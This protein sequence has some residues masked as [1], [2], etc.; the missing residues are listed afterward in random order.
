LGIAV[1][2]LEG[3]LL[4]ANPA[5]CSML[6]YREQ[7]LCAINCSEFDSKDECLLF[8]KLRA[9]LIDHYS[10]EKCYVRKDGVPIWAHLNVS[11][12]NRDESTPFVVAFVEDISK[13]KLIEEALRSSEQRYRVLFERNV[14]GVAIV[15][16]DGKILE[17]NDAWALIVGYASAD[18]IRGRRT[19]DFY[20]N[21]S[22]PEP[23][24]TELSQGPA[25]LV[26]EL[27]L[28]QKDGTPVWVL[29]SMT[30][31]SGGDRPPVIQVISVDITRRKLAE[32]ALSGAAR[33]LIEAQE[34][35]GA[36]VGRELHD[37]IGQRLGLLAVELQQMEQAPPDAA[38][39][40]SSRMQDLWKQASDLS[41]DVQA[42]SHGLRSAK[43][44]YLGVVS[45]MRSHCKEF[46][47]RLRIEVEFR[48]HDLPS[49]LPS[50]EISLSLFRVLQEALHNAAKHSGVRH[51]EV[52]LWGTPSEVHLKVSDS[53]AGFDP[54]VALRGRGIGLTTMKERLKL[55]N[56][57]LSVESRPGLGTMIHARAPLGSQS[58]SISVAG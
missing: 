10:L 52:E 1:E 23:I 51:L 30:L 36:R 29:Y 35:E 33:K 41:K 19:K 42:L 31:I 2:D 17:C 57:E 38:V 58:D 3:R 54:Q 32:E 24:L 45:A 37:D 44:E 12:V 50:P 48:S 49:P 18:E 53:G 40:L 34:R 20:Y 46:A 13:R 8:Q 39:E 7:E 25:F 21:L 26:E 4:R 11:L 16:A 14:A 47:E 15:G 5:L 9:G 43:L 22:T 6:G 55:V 27:Q 28:R 56:G